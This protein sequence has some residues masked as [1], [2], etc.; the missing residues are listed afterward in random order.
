MKRGNSQNIFNF[1]NLSRVRLYILI[2]LFSILSTVLIVIIGDNSNMWI[3]FRQ[4]VSI[5]FTFFFPGYVLVNNIYSVNEMGDVEK[6][7]LSISLSLI[8]VP[9]IGLLSNYMGLGINKNTQ[10]YLILSFI[11][12][13]STIGVYKTYKSNY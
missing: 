10:T 9:S 6:L 13:M 5:P 2:I 1:N 8:I 3:Y 4:V 11:L 12:I 7:A